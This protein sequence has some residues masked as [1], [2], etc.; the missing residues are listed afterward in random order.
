MRIA[1]SLFGLASF[2]P[3]PFSPAESRSGCFAHGRRSPVRVVTVT[4]P[5]LDPDKDIPKG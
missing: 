5:F 2:S 4:L 1:E 3:P